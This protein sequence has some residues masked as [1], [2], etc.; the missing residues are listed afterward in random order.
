MGKN[1][2]SVIVSKCAGNR[3]YGDRIV[4]KSFTTI[5]E[6]KSFADQFRDDG[7]SVIVRPCYNEHDSEGRYFR[8]WRSFN[9][10][11]FREIRFDW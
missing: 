2:V 9:G 10:E 1:V 11:T 4:D 3:I 6:A 5:D 8:E 7:K